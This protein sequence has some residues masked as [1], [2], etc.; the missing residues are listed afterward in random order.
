M[1]NLFL[2]VFCV[3][4]VLIWLSLISMTIRWRMA[5]RWDT[6][7]LIRVSI[8]QWPRLSVIVPAR[9]E[10]DSLVT[11]LPSWFRQDYPDSEIILIDDESNDHTVER[12]KAIAEQCN[13]KIRILHGTTPPSGWTGKLWALQQGICVSSGEWL[14]FTDAD[15]FHHPNLWRGLV[16]KALTEK[17]S[18][19]SLMAL[20]DTKGVWARLLIPAFV[21]FFHMMYPFEKVRDPRSQVSAAA[22]GCILIARSALNKI[23]GIEGHRNAWIDDLALAKRVKQA[24]LPISLS[25]TKSAVSIRP[26][27]KLAEVWKMVA[28]NAFVQLRCSWFLLFFTVLVMATL[29]LI[30]VGGMCAWITGTG[31][32]VVSCISCVALVL[33]VITYIPTLR[34]FGLSIVRAV[35]LPIAG[36]LYAGMT[37]TSAINHLSGMREWRGTRRGK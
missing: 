32:P 27:H 18:M 30:P 10:E 34:F 28:R 11:T 3:V 7:D 19:V 4:S 17:H 6:T 1:L 8:S 35:M 20:L 37:V 25:L 29:F 12:A 33:M 36:I 15:I 9:N 26:Y 31:S 13:S 22:G 21:Y 23:G 5:E 16:A 14:L 2:L 24:S